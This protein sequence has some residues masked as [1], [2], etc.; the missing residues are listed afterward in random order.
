[1]LAPHT[2]L[3]IPNPASRSPS[4]GHQ[5]QSGTCCPSTVHEEGRLALEA[6]AVHQSS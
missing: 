3:M 6:H 4:Q 1:M 5:A 2:S